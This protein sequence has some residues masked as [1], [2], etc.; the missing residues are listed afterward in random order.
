MVYYIVSLIIIGS[1]KSSLLNCLSG[2]HQLLGNAKMS[3]KVTFNGRPMTS[4]NKH[5]LSYVMQDDIF[6]PE[7]TV[8]E[9]MRVKF[10][11]NFN[12]FSFMEKYVFQI[13]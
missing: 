10:N 4:K 3:G 1:G 12:N 8:I 5:L 9:T 2:R 6:F 11:I 7:L 13:L